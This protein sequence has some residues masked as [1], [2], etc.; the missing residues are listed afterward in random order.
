MSQHRTWDDSR[1]PQW[2]YFLQ[3]ESAKK[4][5]TRKEIEKERMTTKEEQEERERN[6][7]SKQIISKQKKTRLY[8]RINGELKEKLQ[9]SQN[10]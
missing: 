7:T 1:S 4:R 6:V 2:K 10:T 9:S 5:K 8:V 3:R